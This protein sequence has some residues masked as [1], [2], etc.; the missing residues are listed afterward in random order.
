LIPLRSTK[1]CR[2]GWRALIA[3]SD[4]EPRPGQARRADGKSQVLG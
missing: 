4:H 1:S 3:R 2:S